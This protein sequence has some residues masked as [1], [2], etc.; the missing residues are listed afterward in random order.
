MA[1]PNATESIHQQKSTTCFLPSSSWRSCLRGVALFFLDDAIAA[2]ITA[3]HIST[4]ARVLRR[5]AF[6]LVVPGVDKIFPTA[7]RVL[8]GPPGFLSSGD[9]RFAFLT[10]WNPRRLDF[11]GRFLW[12]IVM[13]ALRALCSRLDLC[14]PD[15]D[16]DCFLM[17]RATPPLL[18]FP[19]GFSLLTDSILNFWTAEGTNQIYYLNS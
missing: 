9:L 17:L 11:P 2:P 5:R 14:F 1:Y 12:L 10:P 16:G 3:T 13:R 4:R 18:D 7:D 19:G 8:S 15:R 6:G